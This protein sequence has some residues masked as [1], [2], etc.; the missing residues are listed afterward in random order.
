MRDRATI[1]GRLEGREILLENLYRLRRACFQP[2][3][4]LRIY[5]LPQG[6][7]SLDR[8]DGSP[9]LNVQT[10]RGGGHIGDLHPGNGVRPAPDIDCLT[11]FNAPLGID[12]RSGRQFTGRYQCLFPAVVNADDLM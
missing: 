4:A 2:R 3:K 11:R 7:E 9:P 12:C 6:P 1:F 8:S 10:D 5:L